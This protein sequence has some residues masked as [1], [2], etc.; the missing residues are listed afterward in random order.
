MKLLKHN[1]SSEEGLVVY[2]FFLIQS[3]GQWF[4]LSDLILLLMSALS[5]TSLLTTML[6]FFPFTGFTAKFIKTIVCTHRLFL[7]L[8]FYFLTPLTWLSFYSTKIYLL[9]VTNYFYVA[10]PKRHFSPS[11][12]W[13]FEQHLIL[14]STPSNSK[15][16]LPC[17][18]NILLT[19]HPK[20]GTSVYTTFLGQW[21]SKC[22][23][24]TYSISITCQIFG[25]V[26]S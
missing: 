2:F 23:L 26:N 19:V 21:F 1:S 16:S 6:F 9:K 3:G 11:S 24:Q 17:L 8:L 15:F 25:N 20:L 12:Y 22:G 5:P 4:D 18:P 14:F 7:H 10:D 13:T